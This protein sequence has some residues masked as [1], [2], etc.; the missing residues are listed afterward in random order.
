MGT[1]ALAGLAWVERAAE[2]KQ[3]GGVVAHVYM[4]SF[5]LSAGASLCSPFGGQLPPIMVG[6]EDGTC[7]MDDF[8]LRLFSVD[9]A[10]PPPTGYGNI[11]A[12]TAW[13]P[14]PRVPPATSQ[15]NSSALPTPV[16]RIS[17]R[18]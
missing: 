8:W 4:C 14:P 18:P 10:D 9:V 3:S 15:R 1:E 7:A 2:G 6:F 17:W 13:P 12:S 16:W 11:T 5:L